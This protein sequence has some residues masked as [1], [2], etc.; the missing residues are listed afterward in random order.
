MSYEIPKDPHMLA[1]YVNM[2]LRDR[3]ATLTEFCE[4]NG[5]DP[6]DILEKLEDYDGMYDTWKTPVSGILCFYADGAEQALHPSRMDSLTQADVKDISIKEKDKPFLR[7]AT[8]IGTNA[9]N[10]CVREIFFY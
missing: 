2:M 8:Q 7:V 4:D 5:V 6:D 9:F 1:S 10:I 3:Y